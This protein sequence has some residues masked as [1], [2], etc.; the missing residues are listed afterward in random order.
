MGSCAPVCPLAYRTQRD[1]IAPH[2]AIFVPA[3]LRRRWLPRG[4]RTLAILAAIECRQTWCD[5]STGFLRVPRTSDARRLLWPSSPTLPRSTASD[6]DSP[7]LEGSAENHDSLRCD[8]RWQIQVQRLRA[9]ETRCPIRTHPREHAPARAS[10]FLPVFPPFAISL[11]I[12]SAQAVP[13]L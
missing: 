10:P 11:G 1:G 8:S 9:R 12:L 5:K 13:A 2:S 3:I 4:S 6:F 7:R